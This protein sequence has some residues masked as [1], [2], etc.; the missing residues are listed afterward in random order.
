M[1]SCERRV[2][3]RPAVPGAGIDL[4]RLTQ[5]IAKAIDV[6][7]VVHREGVN[8]G[9]YSLRLRGTRLTAVSIIA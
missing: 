6:R 2:R 1:I 4:P 7:E 5:G 9:S 3:D 8:E